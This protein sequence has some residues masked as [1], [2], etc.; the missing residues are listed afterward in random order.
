MVAGDGCREVH[1]AAPRRG[2]RHGSARYATGLVL[3]SIIPAASSLQCRVALRGKT[4]IKSKTLSTDAGFLR[5]RV[6]LCDRCFRSRSVVSALDLPLGTTPEEDLYSTTK[7]KLKNPTFIHWSQQ[8]QGS[9]H[10]LAESGNYRVPREPHR[11]GTC[12]Q[13]APN[14]WTA[15][16]TAFHSCWSH[17]WLGF[18][19]DSQLVTQCA[20]RERS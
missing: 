13:T 14:F 4:W 9:R 1:E 3:S 19:I 5:L 2:E 8:N 10:F 16:A 18:V 6:L 7:A 17:S 15:K 11:C 12:R 20:S